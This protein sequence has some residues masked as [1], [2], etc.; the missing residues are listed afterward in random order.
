MTRCALIL[1]VWLSFHQA[2]SAQDATADN[3]SRF[4]FE[5]QLVDGGRRNPNGEVLHA[6]P[7]PEH[8]SLIRIREHFIRELLHSVQRL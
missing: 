4:D 2:A 1:T 7:R 8:A 5:D 3:V 6:R